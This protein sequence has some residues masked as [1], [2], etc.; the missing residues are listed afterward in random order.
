MC[1]VGVGYD[2]ASLKASVDKSAAAAASDVDELANVCVNEKARDQARKSDSVDGAS[3]KSKEAVQSIVK[4]R[5]LFIYKLSITSE[6]LHISGVV[7][8]ADT[9]PK[10]RLST[11][12]VWASHSVLVPGKPS[13]TGVLR[14]S[15]GVTRYRRASPH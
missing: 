1:E 8:K 13:L 15:G 3:K 5:W 7:D 12:G 14:T 6:L 9:I 10:T 2:V 4:G 11:R